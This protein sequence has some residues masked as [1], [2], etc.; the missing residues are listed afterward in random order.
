MPADDNMSS[1]EQDARI[2]K[3]SRM[4]PTDGPLSERQAA[5]VYTAL[6]GYMSEYDVSQGELSA[7]LGESASTVSLL[8]ARNPKLPTHKRDELLRAANNWIESD[9]AQREARRP[10]NFTMTRVATRM[11]GVAKNVHATRDIGLIYGPAGIGKTCC[12]QA[13]RAE[14]PGSVYVLATQECRSATGL[15]RKIYAASRRKNR[16]KFTARYADLVE[17]FC[18]GARMLIIDQAHRLQDRALETLMDLHDECELPILLIGTFAL[19]KRVT[20]DDDP[21]YGQ[22]SSRIG[23]RIDL[24][25]EITGG[26]R[27]GGGA[28]ARRTFTVDDVRRIFASC[29]L[30]L[31]PD[32]AQMLA[33]I[34]SEDIGHLRR[35]NRLMRY[36]ERFAAK[37]GAATI[38]VLHVERAIRAV[39]NE[40]VDP[41]AVA[42]APAP[43]AREATA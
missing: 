8:I 37:D 34:A 11:F 12:A 19:R 7:G 38:Q 5:E 30:K 40:E 28:T 10:D 25:P 18:G 33:R 32:A 17:T 16:S 43:A 20:D 26:S 31:H 9:H 22:L 3:V 39:T 14:F 23:L 27:S 1:F 13:I 35:V 21:Y 42:A 4:I 36:A 6:A 41:R 29:K 2:R 24:A 15:I